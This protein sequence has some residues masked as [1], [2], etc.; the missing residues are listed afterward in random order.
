MNGE[1][2][3]PSFI[4]F[5]IDVDEFEALLGSQ[6]VLSECQPL[7]LI[8]VPCRSLVEP[9]IKYL[10]WVGYR[11]AW[12]PSVECVQCYASDW[13]SQDFPNQRGSPYLVAYPPSEPLDL[14][15]YF[16]SFLKPIPDKS[17][18]LTQM[19]HYR[20]VSIDPLNIRISFRLEDEQV[21]F[22]TVQHLNETTMN[23]CKRVQLNSYRHISLVDPTDMMALDHPRDLDLSRIEFIRK[24]DPT[25]L[26]NASYLEKLMP[27]LGFNT[28]LSFEQPQ[29]VRE[30]GG[31][32]LIWQYPN[33][34]SK[35]LALLATQR[36]SSYLEIGC[37]WGGTFVFTNEFLKKFQPINRSI[38][39]DLIDSPVQEYCASQEETEFYRMDSQSEEFR[40]FIENSPLFDLILIDGDHSY[41][42][43]RRDYELCRGHGKILVFHDVA[44]HVCPGVA[45]F[46]NELKE[47]ESDRYDFYEFVDQYEEVWKNMHI[48]FLG[49]GVAIRKEL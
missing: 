6:E 47:I 37:R 33:Q 11:L 25:R 14:A 18:F 49:I 40:Q 21:D 35:Y 36:I 44:S 22:F 24:R 31:G 9:L 4:R 39:I 3:C 38:A 8:S 5:D 20:D 48:L 16:P 7:L 32:L 23:R 28:E 17:Y 15:E 1:F 43:V 27:Q 41:E 45:R 2:A 12:L 26:A 46:W 13:M 10:Q 30:N 29:I 19:V 42:G 34:F